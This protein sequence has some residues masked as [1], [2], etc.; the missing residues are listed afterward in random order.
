MR[1]LTNEERATLE[2]W[3]RREYVV[4]ER[5][6]VEEPPVRP[7]ARALFERR[8]GEWGPAQGRLKRG[9][10]P[11]PLGELALRVDAAARAAGVWP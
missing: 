8:L 9:A 2:R 4:I 11:T 1:G 3:S 10:V 5:R 7:E 6:E